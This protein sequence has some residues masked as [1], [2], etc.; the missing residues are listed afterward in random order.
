MATQANINVLSTNE[1]AANGGFTHAVLFVPG[2]ATARHQSSNYL[3]ETTANTSM[4]FNLFKTKPGDVI[5][6]WGLVL[7]PALKNSGDTAFNST[8]FSF[9]DEDTATTYLNAVQTN[10]NGTEV[11]YTY[12]NTA[13][14]YTAIKQLTATVN[15][16]SGKS[17]SSLNTGRIILLIELLRLQ[18]I[19]KSITG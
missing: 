16:M 15:A 1:Q 4:V 18:T 6:K 14:V 2:S 19:P 13:A 11:I 10:E 5:V 7:D 3:S 8:T 12:G 17:L 9:G